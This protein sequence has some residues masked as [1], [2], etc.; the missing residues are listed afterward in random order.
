MSPVCDPG[1]NT[2]LKPTPCSVRASSSGMIPPPRNSVFSG[3]IPARGRPPRCAETVP[4]AHPKAPTAPPRARPPAAPPQRSCPG[5]GECPC[6]SLPSRRRATRA[7]RSSPRGRDRRAPAS[8][9]ARESCPASSSSVM[10]SAATASAC[11]PA[12]ALRCE[13]GHTRPSELKPWPCAP[14]ASLRA[15]E[16]QPRPI[17]VPRRDEPAL[18]GVRHRNPVLAQHRH[19]RRRVAHRQRR[20]EHPL[21][22]LQLTL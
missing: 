16:P 1:P 10:T 6:R 7:P 20:H 2:A 3:V 13:R 21:A 22:A 9:P 18:L 17:R 8:P 4:D 15:R 11:R 14:S 19:R 5:S 12:Y